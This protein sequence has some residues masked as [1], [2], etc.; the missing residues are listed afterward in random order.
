MNKYWAL[1]EKKI[2]EYLKISEVSMKI[3]QKIINVQSQ[4]ADGS[5]FGVLNMK[6]VNQKI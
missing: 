2:K 1:F 3:I 5:T 4:K 6:Q